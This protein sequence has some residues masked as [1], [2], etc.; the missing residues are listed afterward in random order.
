[1]A[2]S[3]ATTIFTCFILIV[4]LVRSKQASSA[5]FKSI[6]SFGDSLADTGNLLRLS[7]PDSPPPPY[8]E[9]Y[10][11]HPTGRFS[12]G[13]LIID[14]IAEAYGLP[15]VPPF[16]GG[17]NLSSGG[18]DGGVNFAVAGSTALPDSFFALHGVQI[19]QRNVSLEAELSWFKRKFLPTFCQQPA[20]NCENFLAT[21][22]VLVGEIGGN[23]Y[24][25]PFIAGKSVELVKTF[26][27]EVVKAISSTIEVAVTLMVPGNLP[28]GCSASYLT[29]FK[30]LNEKDYDP[31]TGCLNWLNRFSQYH[32]TL[33]QQELH[34]IRNQNPKINIIYADYYNAAMN[35]YRFPQKYGFG[36]GA[37]TACC[38]AGGPYNVNSTLMCGEEG[39]TVCKDPSQYVSWDGLHLTEAA[40][41]FIAMALIQG[42][43]TNP[44]LHS[45]CASNHA[46]FSDI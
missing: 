37:L 5:C 21:S 26:V 23:D 32:N 14:F 29:T 36:G 9:T 4:L 1:M 44:H 28:I 39:T 13:R 43:Y 19:P 45:F 2:S 17:K 7:P 10:F 15:L 41:R 31:Q 12:D 8:G 33:L 27:P 18:F 16:Y 46:N 35:F 20:A 40:Y 25:H 30:R 34:R 38:G 6:I 22:L 11:H 42:S 3:S 24:N